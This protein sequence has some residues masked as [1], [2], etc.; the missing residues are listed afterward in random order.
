MFLEYVVRQE[1]ITKENILL[2]HIPVQIPWQ[3][4]PDSC[5]SLYC[6]SLSAM[7]KTSNNTPVMIWINA[8]SLASLAKFTEFSSMLTCVSCGNTQKFDTYSLRY[9]I[10]PRKQWNFLERL[11]IMKP[12]T[13]YTWETGGIKQKSRLGILRFIRCH[14]VSNPAKGSFLKWGSWIRNNG[15]WV[16]F[17]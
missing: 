7:P 14:N 4:T 17:A 3:S 1:F 9:N 2:T 12:I 11:E 10:D 8:R 6:T 5:C 13:Y 16:S 15:L